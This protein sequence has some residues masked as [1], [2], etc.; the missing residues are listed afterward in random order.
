VAR[1]AERELAT[2]IQTAPAGLA[3]NPQGQRHRRR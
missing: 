1:D 3:M 2:G